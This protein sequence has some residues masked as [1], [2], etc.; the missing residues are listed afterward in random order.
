LFSSTSSIAIALD[1]WSAG[2][3]TI[4]HNDYCD[5]EQNVDQP[6]TDVHDEKAENPKDQQNY[7]DGPKHDRILARSELH[8]TPWRCARL[9]AHPDFGWALC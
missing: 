9:D 6:T 7:C 2:D 3:Q 4:D 8:A 5:D 1:D